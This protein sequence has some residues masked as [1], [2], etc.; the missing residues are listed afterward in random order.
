[1]NEIQETHLSQELDGVD[2][3]ELVHDELLVIA[4][5]PQVIN[6]APVGLTPNEINAVSGGPQVLNDGP[7]I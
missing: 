6:D 7:P 5:G 2:S 3:R 1:M 4:G